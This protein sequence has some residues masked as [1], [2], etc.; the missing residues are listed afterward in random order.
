[1]FY[2]ILDP[3]ECCLTDTPRKLLDKYGKARLTMRE[4]DRAIGAF[5]N[6]SK[7]EKLSS[8]RSCSRQ[9]RPAGYANR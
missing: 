5:F 3:Q 6:C 9:T 2:C 7:P 1:M 4:P 8:Q